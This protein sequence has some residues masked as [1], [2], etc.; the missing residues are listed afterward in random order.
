M[1]LQCIVVLLPCTQSI[2]NSGMKWC[3]KSCKLNKLCFGVFPLVG[4][5]NMPM[6]PGNMVTKSKTKHSCLMLNVAEEKLLNT[7]WQLIT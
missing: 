5:R 2:K 1:L 4:R 7:S 3:G 6:T